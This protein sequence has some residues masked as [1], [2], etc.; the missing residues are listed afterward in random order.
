MLALKAIQNNAQL[1]TQHGH[2]AAPFCCNLYSSIW[3]WI[4]LRFER[5]RSNYFDLNSDC[6]SWRSVLGTHSKN[7]PY[8]G[9]LLSNTTKLLTQH[10]CSEIQVAIC[11]TR[12]SISLLGK[13]Y[14]LFFFQRT[15]FASIGT[16]QSPYDPRIL[17]VVT[18]N[19]C[20]VFVDP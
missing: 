17:H 6:T 12:I 7:S 14:A 2:L 5:V 16:C 18:K 19:G 9:H 3:L 13:G 8:S 1:S 20:I 4:A 15:G 10:P 11:S